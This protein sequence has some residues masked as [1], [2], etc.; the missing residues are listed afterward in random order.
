MTIRLRCPC[1]QQMQVP[2]D[3]AGKVCRCPG[4]RETLKVPSKVA[5]AAPLTRP[6]NPAARPS[7][8]TTRPST[9]ASRPSPPASRPS[10]PVSRP[11]NP[12]A[13]PKNARPKNS[14]S[15]QR[16][17]AVAAVA[18][19]VL[20]AAA[21]GWGVWS[22]IRPDASARETADNA[23][24]VAAEGTSSDKA[25]HETSDDFASVSDLANGS[26]S[27][28]QRRGSSSSSDD[29][30]VQI[31]E[32]FIAKAEIPDSLAAIELVDLDAF[33]RRVQGPEGS[34][35]A[36]TNRIKTERALR[37][38][39]ARSF[40]STP[41][42]GAVRHWRVIGKTEYDG[43]PAVVT[44]YYSEPRPPID[45]AGSRSWMTGAVPLV[46]FEEF[47]ERAGTLFREIEGRPG[48]LNP[49]V[50]NAPDG[51]GF[52]PP[53]AGYL[54]LCFDEIDG[55]M[56]LV[57]LVNPMGDL[58]LSRVAGELFLRDWRVTSFGIKPDAEAEPLKPTIFGG[59]PTSSVDNT[60]EL[61][62]LAR[63]SRGKYYSV[64]PDKIGP[65]PESHRDS[66]PRRIH[67]LGVHVVNDSPRSTE[68][69]ERFRN[70]FPDD[71]GGD[72]ATVS[73][74]MMLN[75]LEI[76][77]FT[78]MALDE[79]ATRLGQT[80]PDPFL[81]Y[82]RWVAA[83]AR[84]DDA[85]RDRMAAELEQTG[86][87]TAEYFRRQTRQAIAS[88]DKDALLATLEAVAEY[89][90]PDRTMPTDRQKVN[91]RND[92]SV[93]SDRVAGIER[94]LGANRR[95]GPRGPAGRGGRP[96]V[97]RGP[98]GTDGEEASRPSMRGGNR[99]PA[100]PPPSFGKGTRRGSAGADRSAGGDRSAAG[101]IPPSQKVTVELELSGQFD[102]RSA[103]R[104]LAEVL[105]VS[106]HRYQ[107]QGE[108]ATLT[109]HFAGPL[110]AVRDAI[111]FGTVE[112]V[113]RPSRTL[114]VAVP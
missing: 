13:R 45:W 63:F 70:D 39:G 19:G 64:D 113:V 104:E 14:G 59:L 43:H 36:Q 82:V 66:R 54:L 38:L 8:P 57:D 96:G 109:L 83:D 71:P 79:A 32:R 84:G 102:A 98:P 90:N 107:Q 75:D 89:W 22:A 12:A 47:F 97:L 76:G 18:A 56:R 93:V 60:V 65:L 30:A 81:D 35:A 58:R 10:N 110:Q 85:L 80:W 51:N 91:I 21:F 73:L 34:A 17:V 16:P 92:W 69:L 74:V 67:K 61:D 87:V 23:D 111:E 50:P 28:S 106:N 72:L 37:N 6:P 53:R 29:P 78:A 27:D 44:R 4:C 101:Q 103:G 112:R 86:F 26:A 52:L 48:H 108:R 88:K 33:D 42:S 2:D 40:E 5:T 95:D 49:S 25:S 3:A 11:V 46:S 31:A 55:E 114:H 105:N 24:T 15:R 99:N 62:G 41:K 94:G 9:P 77:E 68:L 20:A 7:K 1:G 100:E